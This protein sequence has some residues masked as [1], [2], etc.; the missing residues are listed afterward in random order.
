MS[1]STTCSFSEILSNDAAC[2]PHPK[3]DGTFIPL[4]PFELQLQLLPSDTTN[5][6][7]SVNEGV[8]YALEYF[9]NYTLSKFDEKEDFDN[10]G[11]AYAAVEDVTLT[12]L[13][14]QLQTSVMWQFSVSA[15]AYYNLSPG[16]WIFSSAPT[17]TELLSRI[18]NV[19]EEPLGD[20][21]TG[22]KFGMV[23]EKLLYENAGLDAFREVVG[24]EIVSL[25]DADDD[26]VD[27]VEDP[28]FE[29]SVQSTSA[30]P[31]A[32]P[33]T[34][35]PTNE[36][37]KYPITIAPSPEPSVQSTNEPTNKPSKHPITIAPSPNP[38]TLQMF[39]NTPTTEIAS[40]SA[41]T[42]QPTFHIT[43]TPTAQPIPKLLYPTPWPT[44]EAVDTV[45]T[46][47]PTANGEFINT[48]SSMLPTITLEDD[49]ELLLI[50]SQEEKVH[51]ENDTV[52]NSNSSNSSNNNAQ[53]ENGI[54]KASLGSTSFTSNPSTVIVSATLIGSFLLLLIVSGAYFITRQGPRRKSDG[55]K[56]KDH[57]LHALSD[58]WDY[59]ME[60]QIKD[61]KRLDVTSDELITEFTRRKLQE[62]D[63]F[64]QNDTSVNESGDT[65]A[66]FDDLINQ[67][68]H[69]PLSPA[70]PSYDDL[71][72]VIGK[73]DEE[74]I[75][76]EEMVRELF[77][78]DSDEESL[79]LDVFHESSPNANG[80]G[81]DI[82]PQHASMLDEIISQ[83]SPSIGAS[84][85]E[86]HQTTVND[87]NK[88]NR[89][90][91]YSASDALDHNA[92]H[93]SNTKPLKIAFNIISPTT[94]QGRRHHLFGGQ[95]SHCGSP[96]HD[97]TVV[98][99]DGSLRSI[100]DDIA[101]HS[102][103]EMDSSWNDLASGE[104]GNNNSS[105]RKCIADCAPASIKDLVLPMPYGEDKSYEAKEIITSNDK[106]CSD[107]F[108]GIR[109]DQDHRDNDGWDFNNIEKGD[110]DDDACD[111]IVLSRDRRK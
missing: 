8:R 50:S 21:Q 37:T 9:L 86:C 107:A 95:E 22:T 47:T 79:K 24:A 63:E 32:A 15:E 90:L 2:L 4:P 13:N 100:D 12:K 77:L 11:F 35:E 66:K 43:D 62:D 55:N 54:D 20:D 70:S 111:F 6:S 65:S 45:Q 48:G 53:K 102:F 58:D 80:G 94:V 73:C 59:D 108:C 81:P 60:N 84:I 52:I 103:P 85:G 3:E 5:D 106:W 14:V 69:S 93:T 83:D 29:P 67:R 88:S 104:C 16:G 64:A 42:E 38:S 1:N 101:S 96:E 61:V 57:P 92:A 41:E 49:D 30:D 27:V 18:Q 25:N 109:T 82:T 19:V 7:D 98:T 46:F 17:S 26:S 89:S 31:T 51:P 74:N 44:Y 23:L 105:W 10:G 110:N 39:T 87:D 33:I 75:A 36:P 40:I 68:K 71:D 97:L 34:A 28:S 99:D 72:F 56:D 91:E 78:I 76:K